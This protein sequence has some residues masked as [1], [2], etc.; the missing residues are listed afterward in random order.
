M[1]REGGV[2]C[3][4][5]GRGWWRGWHAGGRGP[6]LRLQLGRGVGHGCG[7]L[8]PVRRG[9]CC[10]WGRERACGVKPAEGPGSAPPSPTC[11]AAE[12]PQPAAPARPRRAPGALQGADV[13]A[14]GAQPAGRAGGCRLLGRSFS[15]WRWPCSLGFCLLQSGSRAAPPKAGAAPGG[16]VQTD[17]ALPPLC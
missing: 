16:C 1:G 13:P 8:P 17:A 10:R 2:S 12:A 7:L 4:P 9:C 6:G 11:L 15:L 5:L 3:G 14:P